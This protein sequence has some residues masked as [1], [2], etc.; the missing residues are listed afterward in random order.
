MVLKIHFVSFFFFD[1]ILF[2][3][4][5]ICTS[6]SG[7]NQRKL[8]VAIALVGGPSVVL[9]DEPST[10]MD[11]TAKRALWDLL[12]KHVLAAGQP[13]IPFL[14]SY[15]NFNKSKDPVR[16]TPTFFVSLCFIGSPYFSSVCCTQSRTCHIQTAYM[17]CSY[18]AQC[19]V[20]ILEHMS[21]RQ[22]STHPQT[23]RQAHSGHF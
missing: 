13:S 14:S 9:M 10:G 7:G 4:C 22:S 20:V 17:T 18:L 6:Y 5:R 2:G 12:R 11:P 3:R 15:V 8:S 1:L 19:W 23:S 16:S 21:Y